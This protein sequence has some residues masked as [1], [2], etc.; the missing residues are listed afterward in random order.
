MYT[1]DLYI[2]A[3]TEQKMR[4]MLQDNFFLFLILVVHRH[5]ITGLPIDH[6]SYRQNFYPDTKGQ[7][8]FYS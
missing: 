1:D 8:H 6:S 7:I 5:A 4:T 3:E 2:E